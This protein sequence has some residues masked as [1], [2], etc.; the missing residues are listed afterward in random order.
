M[1]TSGNAGSQASVSVIR[2]LTLKEVKFSDLLSIVWKELRV[3][4]VVGTAVAA[5]NFLRIWIMNRDPMVALVVSLTLVVAVVAA[6]L[7]GCALPMLADKIGLDP[8]VMA[9]PLITTIVDAMALI[10]FFNTALL[11]LPAL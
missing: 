10:V 8:V 2:A 7:V 3:S 9:S 5:V 1:D 6:K 11:L 4:L